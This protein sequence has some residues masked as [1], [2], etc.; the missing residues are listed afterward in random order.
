[1][2]TTAKRYI[3]ATEKAIA[4]IAKSFRCTEKYVYLALTYRANSQTAKKIRYAA[5][6]HHQAVPMAHSPQCDTIHL[7]NE[8]NKR[9]WIQY[10]DNG[11]TIHVDTEKNSVSVIDAEGEIINSW[12]D[13]N[14][15][16]FSEIQLYA[17]S[18]EV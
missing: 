2:K 11:V 9:A 1:M 5:V 12:E 17:E 3:D 10:F 13:V 7:L 8:N 18:I 4:M 6:R 15:K 16:K 14:L